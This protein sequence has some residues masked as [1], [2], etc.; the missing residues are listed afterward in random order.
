MTLFPGKD[1]TWGAWTMALW[2]MDEFVMRMVMCYEW[3]FE[4]KDEDRVGGVVE[5]G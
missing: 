2:S 1:M 5:V 4:V 3:Q